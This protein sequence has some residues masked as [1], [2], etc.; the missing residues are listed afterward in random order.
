MEKIY[1][2]STLPRSLMLLLALLLFVPLSHAQGQTIN[3][4][5]KVTSSEDQMGIP[6]VGVLI[7]GTSNSVSTDLDGNFTIS[8]PENSILQFS[9]IGFKS[10]EVPASANLA[11]TMETDT[12]VLEEVVVVGYGTQRKE[13]VTG[14]VASIKGDQ[15]REMPSP[16]VTQA[17]QSR[18]AGVDIAQTSS[19][20]GAALQI[21]IRGARSLTGNNDP[22]I[23]L[24]GIPFGG[25]IADINPGDIKS[26]DILK[27]ASATA[28]YGSRGSNGVILITTNKGVTGQEAKL[29][30]NGYNG[31][32]TVFSRVP[33]MSGPEFAMLRA[34]AGEIGVQFQNTLDESNDV[35]TDWQ[36]LILKK[37]GMITSHDIGISGG[38]EKGSY[39]FS[40]GYFKDESV[41]PLQDYE[42]FSLR[43]SF[44]QHVGN[45]FH[46]GMNTTNNYAV[47]NNGAGVMYAALG[48]SPIIN[49]YNEDGTLKETVLQQTSG[50]Q[51]T[52]TRERF[53]AAGDG[54]VNQNRAFSSYNSLF[55]EFKVPGVEGLKY[56]MNVGLNFRQSNDGSFT[57]KGV[58]NAVSETPSTASIANAVTKEWTVENLLTYDRAFGKHSISAVALYSAQQTEYNRSSASARNIPSDSFQFYNLGQASTIAIDPSQQN[59]TKRGLMSYMGRVM[60]SF[61]DRYMISAAFRSDGASVL[62][63]GN[64]WHSYPAVSAGWNLKKESFMQRFNKLDQLKFRVGYGEA[65]N[66]SIDPYKTLGVLNTRPYNFGNLNQV[67]LYVSEAPNPNL[68]WE[69]TKTWNYGVDFGF[70]NGRLTGTLDYYIQKTSDVLFTVYLPPTAGVN[71]YLGN[72][73]ETQNKGLEFSLNGIIIDNVNN[74]TWSA[75]FNVYA[76]RNEI[77]KLVSGQTRDEGNQFFVGHAINSIYD[78]QYEGLW[79]EGDPNRELLEPGGNVGMIKVLYTGGYNPDGTPIRAIGPDDRQ[80]LDINPK[81]QGGFNTHVTYK[82]FDFSAIGAFQ[83]GGILVSSLYGSSGYLNTLNARSG[84]NVRVDYWTPENTDARYPRPGGIQSGDNPKYGS[85]LA[86][87]DA[88]YVK[89]RTIS[90]GYTFKQDFIKDAGVDRLRI[91][92]TVQNPFVI[93]SPYYKESGM[94]PE[95]NSYGDENV[96]VAGT[97]RIPIVG[98][99]TPVTRNVIIGLNLTF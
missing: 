52:P 93:Y 44:D 57:G 71:N 68:G 24:D 16:N 62:A 35:S 50:A 41:I 59:Y 82:S 89:I 12:K 95:P 37:T 6:G 28:I 88:S 99:N 70:F 1:K 27:D 19:R 10:Q 74:F 97:R 8:A 53:E 40:T 36:D 46:F 49:P 54:F 39:N 64:K 56:R 15:L 45:Y 22:L 96:A 58:Y 80:I 90:L 73:A 66:Q 83:H 11:I 72:V 2:V 79:Q 87:F 65:S 92:C 38:T 55:G 9:S 21:R 25:S 20:P 77:T 76:N 3:V 85:T 32:R 17:L 5:G 13:A 51:W 78:Y 30:Y 33:M 7:K 23:V 98:T 14:S 43:G 34:A 81:Y 4:T 31:I 75:G 60:Y 86:Y 84:N 42:R 29:T 67:G 61:D 26:L 69:Y 94:D 47:T 63:P 18:I 48:L 91:Y